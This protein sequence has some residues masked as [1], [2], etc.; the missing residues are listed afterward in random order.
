MK[1]TCRLCCFVLHLMRRFLQSRLLVCCHTPASL[2][3]TD[4]I[5]AA[6]FSRLGQRRDQASTS[7]TAAKSQSQ[8]LKTLHQK[9]ALKRKNKWSGRKFKTAPAEKKNPQWPEVSVSPLLNLIPKKP[10]IILQVGL[11]PKLTFLFF[12]QQK[13]S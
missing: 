3:P 5:L 9:V 2:L 1:S 10:L 12:L 4:C 7:D 6:C 8:Q 13:A 11:I